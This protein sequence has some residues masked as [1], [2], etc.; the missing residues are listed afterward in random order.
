MELVPLLVIVWLHFVSDFILQTHEMAINK[1]KSNVWLTKH[2]VAY[3]VP[4]VIVF[5][6]TYAII[7]GV[8]HWMTDWCSSRTNS[9]FWAKGDTHNFFVSVGADQAVHM[10]TM[11]LTF[12]WLQPTILPWLKLLT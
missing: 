6:T 1:S 3:T 8:L 10:T 11:I 5:G 2:I 4:F 9:Y 12:I 7:N